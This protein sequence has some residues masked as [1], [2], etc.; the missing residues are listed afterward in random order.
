MGVRIM[1][2]CGCDADEPHYSCELDSDV[3][4]LW[5]DNSKVL[6]ELGVA[7]LRSIGELDEDESNEEFELVRIE[8]SAFL[9]WL[10]ALATRRASIAAAFNSASRPARWNDRDLASTEPLLRE[11][12]EHCRSEDVHVEASHG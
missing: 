5:F 11:L 3:S 6:N 1:I 8:P 9:D 4:E 7:T 10:D 2:T 12:A